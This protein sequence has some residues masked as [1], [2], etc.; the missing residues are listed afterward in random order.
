MSILSG[1]LIN[2]ST[3]DGSKTVTQYAEIKTDL[4]SIGSENRFNSLSPKQQW[5]LF[6]PVFY[7]TDDGSGCSVSHVWLS[8]MLSNDFYKSLRFNDGRFGGYPTEGTGESRT[9]DIYKIIPDIWEILGNKKDGG[10]VCALPN[11]FGKQPLD[12]HKKYSEFI[13]FESDTLSLA[14]QK[15]LINK[16]AQNGLIPYAVVFSGSNSYHVLYPTERCED[17]DKWGFTSKLFAHFGGD[18][19]VLGRARQLMRVPGFYRAYKEKKGVRIDVQKWQTLEFIANPPAYSLDYVAQVI[20]DTLADLGITQNCDYLVYKLDSKNK[21]SLSSKTPIDLSDVGSE[22]FLRL[23]NDIISDLKGIDIGDDSGT[24]QLISELFWA[25]CRF[26]SKDTVYL[27]FSTAFPKARNWAGLRDGFKKVKAGIPTIKDHMTVLTGSHWDLPD[28]LS[29]AINKNKEFDLDEW[30]E[31]KRQNWTKSK[32]LTV[33]TVVNFKY[34]SEMGAVNFSG[35]AFSLRSMLGTGK[36]RLI[37]ISLETFHMGDGVAFLSSRNGLLINFNA[38]MGGRFIHILED[39]K[40]YFPSDPTAWIELCIDSIM[41]VPEEWWEGKIILLDEIQSILL[42]LCESDT[43]DGKRLDI[44]ERFLYA[45]RVCKSV[46]AMDG[47]LTDFTCRFISQVCGTKKLVILDNQFKGGRPEIR[48]I[49][50]VWEGDKLKKNTPPIDHL[51][52]S[53]VSAPICVFSDSRT[54]LET[55]YKILTDL[56]YK[57]LLLTSQTSRSKD[58]LEFLGGVDGDKEDPCAKWILKHRPDFLLISPSAESGVDISK[59]EG[60]FGACYCFYHGVLS[61]DNLKQLMMR[62]RDVTICRYVWLR[63]RSIQRDNT[64]TRYKK[65][66]IYSRLMREINDKDMDLPDPSIIL[67]N[68]KDMMDSVPDPVWELAQSFHNI[69][70]YEMINFRESFRESLEIG[71]YI[72]EDCR[73]E[74][75][76]ESES[77]F[78]AVKRELKESECQAIADADDRYRLR[79]NHIRNLKELNDPADVAAF[80]K[81]QIISKIPFLDR[82]P[83]WDADLIYFLRFTRPNFLDA[84]RLFILASELELA[85]LLADRRH[86]VAKDKD[87]LRERNLAPWEIKTEYLKAKAIAATGILGLISPNPFGEDDPLVKEIIGKAKTKAFREALG[88]APGSNPMG[89]ICWLL[90]SMGY[91]TTSRQLRGGDDRGQRIYLI[92]PSDFSDYRPYFDTVDRLYGENLFGV[93]SEDFGECTT[94]FEAICNF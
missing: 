93:F 74:S 36:T 17:W 77:Q 85:R 79:P 40:S 58:C 88:K 60:Y 39:K 13:F 7:P 38:A 11:R 34:V 90:G 15:D 94:N 23:L 47:H 32:A 3:V 89:W 92:S 83:V 27:A 18:P 42:H 63:A 8:E 44:I 61:V 73:I 86:S 25:L 68:Y 64:D 66:N 87:L 37:K 56:G 19:N 49:E 75:Q 26:L 31:I 54:D 71:G 82:E 48:L 69:A 43:L 52:K 5:E 50:G 84:R 45:L 24:Y 78:K 35:V 41:R 81:A 20:Q 76:K 22:L 30:K 57:G 2:F 46:V 65:D 9:V 4:L 28:Y 59:V 53:I 10:G 91:Q 72:V 33:G 62:L 80:E 51:K 70:Q 12:S 14:E 16:L 6:A 67:Q 55:I 1:N 21:E 29:K